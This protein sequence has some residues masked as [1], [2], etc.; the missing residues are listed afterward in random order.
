MRT[1]PDQREWETEE[2]LEY[3]ELEMNPGHERIP[4]LQLPPP[5][6]SEVRPSG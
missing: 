2:E 6:P 5:Q 3:D 4:E 1:Y